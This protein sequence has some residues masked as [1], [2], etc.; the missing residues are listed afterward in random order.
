[1][2]I[3]RWLHLAGAAALLLAPASCADTG[4]VR[5]LAANDFTCPASE[6]TVEVA[7]Q[8][9]AGLT[10]RASGCNVAAS[11]VCIRDPWHSDDPRP[12]CSRGPFEGDTSPPSPPVDAPPVDVPPAAPTAPFP[13][14][15]AGLAFGSTP[16]EAGARCAQAGDTW[17]AADH[18]GFTCDHAPASVGFEASVDARFCAGKLCGIAIL[19]RDPAAQA[20]TQQY[21]RVRHDLE[22]LYGPPTS[23]ESVLPEGCRAEL[24]RCLS[25]GSAGFRTAWT[26]AS[27]RT[28]TLSMGGSDARGA[29][30]VLYERLPGPA[31]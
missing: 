27:R 20:S 7:S 5:A 19:A 28:V 6:I 12:W 8:D 31:L 22:D 3:R 21:L 29:L 15:A 23:V 16:A 26:W 18:D 11:Y 2:T 1:M 14:G 30:R 25:D 17:A 24:P 9:P 13:A 4:G 10:Y